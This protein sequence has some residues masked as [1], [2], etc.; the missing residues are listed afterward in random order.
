MSI[1][2]TRLGRHCR[3]FTLV[4]LITSVAILI[5]LL[6][7]GIPG[8]RTLAGN[9]QIS[10]A[11]NE[12]TAHLHLARSEAIM[13]GIPTVLCPSLD[14]NSCDNS[15]EWAPGLILYA[16]KDRDR[17]HDPDEVLLRY[18]RFASRQISIRTSVGR[19]TLRYQ[20]S[21]LS[22]GSTATITFCSR[23]PQIQPKAIIVSNAG[24]PRLSRFRPDG[25]PLR[26]S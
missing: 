8:I 4:E 22:P 7:I 21:G 26:C 13:R 3:A 25:S 16:D 19:K 5:I 11:V 24:R 18:H 12:M 2:I 15:T 1:P 9:S 23:Q 6:S 20:P 10:T 17:Q 14:G